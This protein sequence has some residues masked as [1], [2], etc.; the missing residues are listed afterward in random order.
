MFYVNQDMPCKILSD[1]KFS[2][3][4]EILTLELN[5]GKMKWLIMGLYKPPSLKADL[6]TSELN[7][8]LTYYSTTYQKHNSSRGLQHVH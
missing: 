4:I 6:F 2:Q 7:K 1:F 3:E 5:L 8:A